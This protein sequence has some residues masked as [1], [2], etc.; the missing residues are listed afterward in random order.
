MNQTSVI[1][2][3]I[4]QKK[5]VTQDILALRL[6]DYIHFL[7]STFKVFVFFRVSLIFVLM[8]TTHHNVIRQVWIYNSCCRKQTAVITVR[9]REIAICKVFNIY[10]HIRILPSLQE[11]YQMYLRYWEV[12]F[13]NG[14]TGP[15][16]FEKNHTLI[17]HDG[18][19][20]IIMGNY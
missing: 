5:C 3:S 11:K 17:R 18:G 19:F 2:S 8:F 14:L 9:E 7:K 20:P 10:T 13:F 15:S 6:G 1:S 4:K 12:F 16:S